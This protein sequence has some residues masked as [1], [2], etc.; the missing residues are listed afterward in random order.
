VPVERKRAFIYLQ[1][2]KCKKHPTRTH[3]NASSLHTYD[4]QSF[5]TGDKR[6]WQKYWREVVCTFLTPKEYPRQ[7]FNPSPGPVLGIPNPMTNLLP[8]TKEQSAS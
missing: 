2:Q 6:A 5:R 7:I 3:T 8:S 4:R 1:D